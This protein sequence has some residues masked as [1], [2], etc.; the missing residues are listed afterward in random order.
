M[1][2][3]HR[4]TDVV[5]GCATGSIP[6]HPPPSSNFLASPGKAW[7]PCAQFL[8]SLSSQ[9]SSP[10]GKGWDVNS[11]FPSS[12]VLPAFSWGSPLGPVLLLCVLD[13]FSWLWPILAPQALHYLCSE[14]PSH[15]K[16]LQ[17]EPPPHSQT[18]TRASWGLSAVCEVPG[19]R[20]ELCLTPWNLF[21][22]ASLGDLWEP[23]PQCQGTCLCL[24]PPFPSC[25]P[26][27]QGGCPLLTYA[28]G[29]MV[30]GM[31]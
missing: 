7:P 29:E 27:G 10:Q 13:E 16:L 5:F 22:A 14:S 2:E 18:L 25:L 12:G 11:H 20:L 4:G 28:A 24:F 19:I 15:Y 3:G 8:K 21:T 9:I 6:L 1:S 23:F 26:S 17:W 30:L 31:T